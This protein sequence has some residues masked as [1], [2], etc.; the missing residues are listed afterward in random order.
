MYLSFIQRSNLFILYAENVFLAMLTVAANQIPYL[1]A[2]KDQY[3]HYMRLFSF[4]TLPAGRK[5]LIGIL[6]AFSK[7]IPELVVVV[8]NL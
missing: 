1:D 6:E 3:L 5:A 7:R 4:T 8:R 2:P